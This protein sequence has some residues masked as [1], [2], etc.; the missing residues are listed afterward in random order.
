MVFRSTALNI[1]YIAG[2]LRIPFA[3]LGSALTLLLLILFSAGIISVKRRAGLEGGA[4]SALALII[5]YIIL[6]AIAVY[7]IGYGIIVWVML[8]VYILII[9]SAV[10]LARNIANAGYTIM[11]A[12]IRIPDITVAALVIIIIAAGIAAG[13][14]FFSKLPMRWEAADLKP[15]ASA[16][17]TD[18][19]KVLGFPETV[20]ND[21]AYEDLEECRGADMVM[22]SAC[23]NTGKGNGTYSNGF[24]K[25]AEGSCTT[26][27]I[28][29]RIPD[30]GLYRWFIIDCFYW[31]G[32]TRFYGNEIMWLV[33]IYSRGLFGSNDPPK[34]GRVYCEV[35]GET[36]T[37]DYYF[38][39][40]K[41]LQTSGIFSS[42][43][44]E[45]LNVAMWSFPAKAVNARG[46][47]T[48]TAENDAT[49]EINENSLINY[50]HQKDL[51][52]YPLRT[53][54]QTGDMYLFGNSPFVLFNN[55]FMHNTEGHDRLNR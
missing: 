29:V 16:E 7:G 31:N 26:N 53:V 20:L 2:I 52:N 30:G 15:S 51:I 27:V 22:V 21:L 48:Y 23:V 4:G 37:S 50:Y 38:V 36:L 44:S 9:V 39:G 1:M 35:N 11:P 13:N 40:E 10:R 33:P 47:I 46:Y 5:W 8:A 54:L 34:T 3:V 32:E 19:L 14:I 49:Y 43:Q 41:T 55:M 12:E 18:N 28:M 17:I 45:T 42:D 6:C 25:G 24:I